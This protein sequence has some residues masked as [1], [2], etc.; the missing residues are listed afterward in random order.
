M[1]ILGQTILK[2]WLFLLKYP[3]LA[4][5]ALGEILNFQIPPKKFY[6]INYRAKIIFP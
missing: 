6:N 5:L 3:I 4:V 1:L 2:N